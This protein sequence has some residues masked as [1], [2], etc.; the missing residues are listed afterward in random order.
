MEKMPL[1]MPRWA[2]PEVQSLYLTTW[3]EKTNIT[4]WLRECRDRWLDVLHGYE[5]SQRHFRYLITSWSRVL[6][7]KLTGFH[8][9]KKFSAFYRTRKF[10]TAF[11]SVLHLSLSWGNSILSIPP[12]SISILILF[13]HL[14]LG[15]PSGMSFPKAHD[16]F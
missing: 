3:W 14:R 15:L 11:T 1:S 12:H 16:N 2:N 8:L 13:S 10:I 9:D 7:E 4:W 6:L 5:G